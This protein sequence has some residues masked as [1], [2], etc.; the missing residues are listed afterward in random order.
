[1]SNATPLVIGSSVAASGGASGAAYFSG[2]WIAPALAP[3]AGALAASGLYA[4]PVSL[5]RAVSVT[6]I[7]CQVTV[8]AA[9][10]FVR[11]GIY[12]DN[13]NGYPGDLV[14]GSDTGQIDA[15]GAAVK[16]FTYGTPL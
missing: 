3:A 7:A 13:G 15:S 10:S 5:P 9:S 11:M 14:A 1:M 4:S 2:G 16:T 8:G 12:K 6:D